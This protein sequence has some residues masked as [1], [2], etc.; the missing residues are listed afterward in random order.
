MFAASVDF[1]RKIKNKNRHKLSSEAAEDL[2]FSRLEP[3]AQK[4]ILRLRQQLSTQQDKRSGW[5]ST[6][7]PMRHGQ[8]RQSPLNRDPPPKFGETRNANTRASAFSKVGQRQALPTQSGI[9]VPASG[10]VPSLLTVAAGPQKSGNRL[11]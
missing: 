2:A 9:S 4:I 10:V 11:S 5:S 7:H 3:S 6:S 1:Q 8:Y